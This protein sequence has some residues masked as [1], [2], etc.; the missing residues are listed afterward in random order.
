MK[1]FVCAAILFGNISVAGCDGNPQPVKN[2]MPASK[3]GTKVGK[4]KASSVSDSID[5]LPKI[6][7]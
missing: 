5:D 2:N 7:K 3:M 4:G 6:T 1:Y